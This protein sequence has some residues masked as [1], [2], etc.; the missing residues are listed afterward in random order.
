M[1]QDEESTREADERAETAER[2]QEHR[3]TM[4][5]FTALMAA[6]MASGKTAKGAAGEA[7]LAMAELR[8]RF[9]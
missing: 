9:T 7:D 6:S 3:F 8:K 4:P 5:L 1:A 2:L